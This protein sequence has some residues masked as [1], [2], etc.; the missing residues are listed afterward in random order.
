MAGYNKLG[1]RA[2]IRDSIICRQVTDL[3]WYGKVETTYARAKA[4]QRVAEK[5]ITLAVNTHQDVIKVTKTVTDEKGV[6]TKKEVVND[7]PSKLNAR[8]KIMAQIYDI[9]EKRM[10]KESKTAFDARTKDI[11]HPL[12]EKIFNVYGPR[13]AARKEE[14]GQ[15]GGYTRVLKIGPR[16]G[17][18][19]EMAIIQL[20]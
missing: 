11:F 4:I 16:R 14:L 2:S 3:L 5:I 12:V 19:A 8:R 20:V 7:G 13:Y 10:P 15:G 9:Q 17:D 6:Q 18:A 1:K